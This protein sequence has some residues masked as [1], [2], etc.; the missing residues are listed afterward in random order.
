MSVA[1]RVDRVRDVTPYIR[2]FVLR[3]ASGETLPSYVP[4]SHIVL[5]CGERRNAYSLTGDGTLPD[6][7]TIAVLRCP[8]G[9]GGSVWMHGVR[10]GQTLR[11]S[12][13]RSAFAP[14]ATA[15]HHL[16]IAGGVGITP[17]LSHLRAARRWGRSVSLL[18]AASRPVPFADTLAGLAGA[19]MQILRGRGVM[20][21]AMATALSQQ[22]LGSHMYVCGPAG[23]MQ[24]ALDLARGLGWPAERC[25]AERFTG[26]A[27]A[28]GAP[29]TVRLR[30]SG[31][32]IAVPGDVS[33]LDTLE[34]AGLSLPSLCRQGVCGECRLD[35]VAGTL[36]HRDL[37]LSAA[38]RDGQ[39]C[40][41]PCV[42]RAKGV[43]ALDL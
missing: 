29:F 7:F 34:A 17:M 33:L 37:V 31:R 6:H 12:L 28:D 8:G 5:E 35:G 1:L 16:L 43:L 40:L 21:E 42:S 15:R 3:P 32:T 9:Q 14:I 19:D 11:S 39:A 38:E 27:A 24:A 25:H 22:K 36:L 18:Y 30:R 23:L 13:P 4:G 10:V 20:H 41:M 26:V 2:E